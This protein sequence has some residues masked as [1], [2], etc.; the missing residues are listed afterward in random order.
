MRILVTGYK[1]QLGYDVIKVLEARGI[2]CKGVDI[3]DF[4]LTDKDAVS[5]YIRNYQ[6]T[7]VVH[8]AAYTAVD[9]AEDFK[10]ICY[11]VNVTGTENIANA[12]KEIDASMVYISTDYV[13]NGEGDEPFETTSV[14][15]PKSVYGL[16]KSQ[17]EDKVTSILTKYFIIRTAW[18]FGLNGNNFVKTMIRLGKEREEV[19]VVNDQFGSPTYTADLSVLICDLIATEKYG[20]YHGTNENFCSWYDFAVAIMQEASL[21]ARVLPVSSEQYSAKAARPKNSRLSK[22]SLD[23]AGFLRLPDWQD[24]LH[25]YITELNA[26][27]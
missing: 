1:G 20:V 13:F 16:T 10:D 18:V 8:C 22:V 7:T 24:A 6:P 12:C 17:G 21:K 5:S 19:S 27:K 26:A 3:D 25:R 4:D 15:A 14:K 2:Q 23:T 11:A 9:K